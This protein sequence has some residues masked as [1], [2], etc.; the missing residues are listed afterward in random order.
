MLLSVRVLGTDPQAGVEATLFLNFFLLAVVSFYSLGGTRLTFGSML[1]L[2]SNRWVLFFLLFSGCSLMWSSTASLPAAIA[3]WCAMVADV[4][5]V[6][7]LLRTD[8]VTEVASS[9]MKGFVWG[10]CCI[11]VIAWIM[12]AQSDLRLGDEELLGPNQIG[13]I[14]A[15]AIFLAQYLIHRKEGH[16]GLPALFLGVTLLRS[17]SKT[18]I[19]AFLLSEAF[20]LVSDRSIGRKTKV[21][22]VTTAIFIVVAFRGLLESYYE[23]YLNAGNQA[24]TLTG[25]IGIWAV[26]LEA[27][28]EQPWI[29]H[30]FHSMWKVIPAFGEFEARHAQNELLQQFYTYGVVGIGMLAGL[31]GSFY[32]QIRRLPRGP[33]KTFALSLLIFV[34]VRG[35]AE[36][37]PFDFLLPLWAILLISLLVD[38]TLAVHSATPT[39]V[40]SD[41]EQ[42]A[43]QNKRAYS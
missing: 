17:L 23:V 3:F 33:M 39:S 36:S 15:F 5:I 16:W 29:G 21:L 9:L 34:L 1:Q 11:S 31:Y 35:L 13:Y 18:T 20:L 42:L 22:L 37:E 8:P 25:R 26:I 7:L 41:K 10:A 24:E 32:W 40:L 4:A 27:A 2:W 43:P 6:A 28:L 38:H 14:C 12:P 30:G 19:L